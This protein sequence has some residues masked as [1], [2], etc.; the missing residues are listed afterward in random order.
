MPA[1]RL[2][3]SR[4]TISPAPLT[5]DRPLRPTQLPA[6]GPAPFGA[7][8]VQRSAARAAA[9]P[10]HEPKVHRGE[11]VTSVARTLNARAFSHAGDVYIPAEAGSLESGTGRSLLAHEM[12]HVRQQRELGASRPSP[13]TD[14]GLALETEARRAESWALS[15]DLTLASPAGSP[16]PTP[17]QASYAHAPAGVTPMS[18]AL[19]SAISSTSRGHA[20]PSASTTFGGVQLADDQPPAAPA[21]PDAAQ[22]GALPTGMGERELQELLRQLYPKLRLQ[23]ANELL[24]ARERAG[25]LTDLR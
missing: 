4:Q 25:L 9:Q 10:T 22:S 2:A 19:A 16:A 24:V 1:T 18:P 11:P 8:P 6:T 23:L 13:E 20:M 14:Q 17:L 15:T 5:V 3:S 21:G 12:T 7:A